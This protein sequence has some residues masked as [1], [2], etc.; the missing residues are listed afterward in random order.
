MAPPSRSLLTHILPSILSTWLTNLRRWTIEGVREEKEMKRGRWKDHAKLAESRAQGWGDPYK[1]VPSLHLIS[2]PQ[3]LW[4]WDGGGGERNKLISTKMHHTVLHICNLP[5]ILY[6]F[7]C[8][9]ILHSCYSFD[10]GW[11][12]HLHCK[13]FWY[14][15]YTSIIRLALQSLQYR[16]PNHSGNW[17]TS[18]VH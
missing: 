17:H 18:A 6:F 11:Q 7:Y 14:I 2:L 1:W 16:D 4:A 13:K 10:H 8:A 5:N 15:D 9:Y 3:Y 12:C